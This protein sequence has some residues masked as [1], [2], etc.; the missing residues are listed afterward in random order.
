M[1]MIFGMLRGEVTIAKGM[2]YN[3][4]YSDIAFTVPMIEDFTNRLDMSIG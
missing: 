2:I 1:S 3:P 4:F